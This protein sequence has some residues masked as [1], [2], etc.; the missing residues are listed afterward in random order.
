MQIAHLGHAAVLVQTD[1][2]RIL[3]D[4][5]HFT[6]HWHGTPD[7][8]AVLIT[9]IHPDHA[10]PEKL[11]EL[12]SVNPGAKLL[13][14]PSIT[15][16]MK[17]GKFPDLPATPFGAGDQTVIGDLLISGVGGRHAV[18]HTDLE[19]IG[20]VGFVISSEGQPTLFHPG[21]SY[22]AVPNGIDVLAIPS[23]GP[24]AAIKETV[25]FVRAVGALEGFPIH[26]ELLSDQG[27]NTVFMRINE[28]TDTRFTDLR[29][30]SAHEF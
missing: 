20:N 21:D 11:P 7:L 12:M 2:A 14:E 23:Y 15:E 13:V 3:L 10:D 30:G 26:D 22:E 19:R 27:R 17:D 18:I 8:D 1:G 5:G 4:P 6:G 16:A 28:M 25:D 29:G 24:W 9:H